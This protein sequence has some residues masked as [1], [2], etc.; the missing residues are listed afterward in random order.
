MINTYVQEH[1]VDFD[2]NCRRWK[3]WQS[4]QRV[5]TYPTLHMRVASPEAIYTHPH[6]VSSI[7]MAP[8]L[9]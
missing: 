3:F 8:M 2:L 4:I 1:C 9:T 6:P 5:C 7:G